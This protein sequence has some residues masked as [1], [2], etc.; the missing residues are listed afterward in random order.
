M[1]IDAQI[2]AFG[3]ADDADALGRPTIGRALVAAGYATSVEDAFSRL[4]GLGRPAYVRREGLGPIEAIHAIAA[5]GGLPVL[6]HFAEAPAR[7]GLLRELVD[8]G[9]RGL[10]VYYRS[11]DP[12]TVE[13]VGGVAD[14]LGLIRTGGTDYHGDTGTYAAEHATTWVPPE[15]GTALLRR[16]A[17]PRT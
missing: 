17:S 3:A 2:A 11:F 7:L 12:A 14:A 1:P 16:L 5:V 15:V 10:E 4:I 13:A 9:L 8:V 6:A